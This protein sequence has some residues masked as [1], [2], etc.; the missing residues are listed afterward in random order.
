M[1][2]LPAP[3]VT[4]HITVFTPTVKLEGALLV[5]E[6]TEQLS[7]VTGVPKFTLLTEIEQT[8]ADAFTET[9]TGAVMVGD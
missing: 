3:S 8:P 9:F 5:T 7:L 1:A 6:A 2:V 4:V